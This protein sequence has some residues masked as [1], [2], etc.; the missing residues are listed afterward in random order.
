MLSIP[1][2]YIFDGSYGWIAHEAWP[3]P[4]VPLTVSIDGDAYAQLHLSSPPRR[5]P[6]ISAVAD[7][8][9]QTCLMGL[10]MLNK[11]GLRKEHLTKVSKRVLAAN[12]EEIHILGAVF[13]RLS[14]QG[15]EGQALAT[16]A[17]VCVTDSASRFTSAVRYSS[18]SALWHQASRRSDPPWQAPQR[19]PLPT[20][21]QAPQRQPPPT[22]PQSPGTVRRRAAARCAPH[23]RRTPRSCRSPRHQRTRTACTLG[24]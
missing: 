14:G 24:S 21:L 3:H 8:G 15:V 23:P 2:H 18:S 19:Q 7:S 9:A 4:T 5:T 12:N 17:M 10:Q 11:L 13:L 20:P 16:S 22:H 6:S 1:D